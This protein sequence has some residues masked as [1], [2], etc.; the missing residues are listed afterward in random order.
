MNHFKHLQQVI[1]RFKE[2]NLYCK[3]TKRYFFKKEV[4]LIGYNVNKR[5]F[6][7]SSSKVKAMQSWPIS[8]SG[9]HL[10]GFL[11]LE[12]YYRNF[13]SGFYQKVLPNKRINSLSLPFPWRKKA[14]TA[15]EYIK[16]DFLTIPFL[17]MTSNTKEFLL[18]VVAS[19]YAVGAVLLHLGEDGVKY[20]VAYFG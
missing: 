2:F 15:F 14:Q 9:T 17:L 8:T 16:E 5:G 19:K 1:K 13:A 12:S 4:E 7:I 3:L 10:R 6:A 18:D 20:S 11:G